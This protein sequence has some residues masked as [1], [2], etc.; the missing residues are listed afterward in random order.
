LPY[1]YTIRAA[2]RRWGDVRCRR[3]VVRTMPAG[4][5]RDN[6]V[7]LTP[8]APPDHAAHA[9]EWTDPLTL[10]GPKRAPPIKS[11]AEYLRDLESKDDA[12]RRLALSGLIVR[13]DPAAWDAVERVVRRDTTPLR[14]YAI[15]ALHWTDAARAWPVFQRLL[16]ADPDLKWPDAALKMSGHGLRLT[17]EAATYDNC[18]GLIATLCARARNRDAVPLLC[19]A[20]GKVRHRGAQ[21]A[22]LRALGKLGD[23]QAREI[24]RRFAGQRDAD[25]STIAIEAAARLGDRE[26]IPLL[27]KVLTM[28]GSRVYDIRQ[29]HAIEAAAT[30]EAQ[31]MTDLLLPFLEDK[32]GEMLRA[33]AAEALAKIGEP[34]QSIPA[35]ETAL[36]V[37]SF[38][39]AKDRMRAALTA[40]RQRERET[41][42]QAPAR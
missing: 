6:A 7:L 42:R 2:G 18:A 19:E 39:W 41:P 11:T 14:Y 17:P 5:A 20:L 34:A 35:I 40:L 8:P 3:L 22:I 24:V 30:L 33:A 31:G 27:R 1:A 15:Q 37:E 16:K 23:P 38:G 10:N 13:R 32:T 9:V 26:I 29:L 4:E 12:V 21:W 36:Q 25:A 28:T